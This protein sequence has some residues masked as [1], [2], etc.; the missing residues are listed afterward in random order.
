[1]SGNQPQPE[2]PAANVESL[3]REHYKLA[4]YLTRRFVGPDGSPMWDD[5]LQ[6]A[7]MALWKA[8]QRYDPDR[9]NFASYAATYIRNELIAESWR[10]SVWGFNAKAEESRGNVELRPLEYRG[11]Q[12]DEAG[13]YSQRHEI[14]D[15]EL[16]RLII[17]RLPHEKLRVVAR[18]YWLERLHPKTIAHQMAISVT[19]IQKLHKLAMEE[20][21]RVSRAMDV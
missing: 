7:F 6:A 15:V 9:G 20:M 1:M 12:D 5:L 19:Q 18:R 13:W 11:I 17:K 10:H 14:E 2:S 3:W 21:R 8:C 16:L 4:A